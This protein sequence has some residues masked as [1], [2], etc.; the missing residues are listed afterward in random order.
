MRARAVLCANS[1]ARGSVVFFHFSGHGQQVRDKNGDENDGLDE[2]I[3]PGDAQDQS[4]E[5]GERTNIVDDELA[6]W[7]RTLGDY[8][9]GHKSNLRLHTQIFSGYGDS[10]I[11]YNR[12]RTVFSVGFSLLDF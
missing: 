6:G 7:L 8:R 5:A 11:D 9:F 2:S 3:V 12:R 4:A 1:A 10:L